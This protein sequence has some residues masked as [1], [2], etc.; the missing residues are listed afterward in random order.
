VQTHRHRNKSL[1]PPPQSIHSLPAT[2]CYCYDIAHQNCVRYRVIHKSLW[3]FQP[4]RYSRW[5][6]HAEEEHV[7]RGR[8][9]P[10]FCPTL[11]VLGMSTQQMSTC[12]PYTC[13]MVSTDG[14]CQPVR[15]A[16]HRQP[17][18]W[19]FTNCFVR[20]WSCAVHSPKPPLHRHS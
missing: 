9:T 5:D 18:C 8:N 16:A 20:K 2:I 13:L 1:L 6:G 17:L 11:Q 3:D 15:F 7:N 4:L 19:N 12:N 10:S 14:P